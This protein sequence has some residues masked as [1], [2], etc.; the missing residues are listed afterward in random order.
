MES[1][2]KKIKVPQRRPF[3]I[4]L[5]GYMYVLLFGVQGLLGVARIMY[6]SAAR[7]E[8]RAFLQKMN[9]QLTAEQFMSAITLVLVIQGTF[10]LVHLILGV[11]ILFRQAWSRSILIYLI[12]G[13]VLI[14]LLLALARPALAPYTFISLLYPAFVFW[15][16]TKPEIKEWFSR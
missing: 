11:G 7:E 5:V 9:F 4:T 15:Y 1:E 3:G 6:K 2:S 14:A 12:F 10:S 8:L 16:F 13:S